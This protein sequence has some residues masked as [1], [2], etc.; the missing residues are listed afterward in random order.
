MQL[1]VLITY[2]NERGLLSECLH[3]LQLQAE[4]PEEI[5]IY[6]DASKYP[7]KDYLINGL[8]VKVIRGETG[9]GPSRGRNRLLGLAQSDYIH[10]H[11]AD[12][13]F[14]PGWAHGIREAIGG[15]PDLILTE[16]DSLR[17]GQAY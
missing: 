16:L 12:D 9:M 10:F 5:W 7:A 2:H 3:S 4:P 1:G 13:F 17:D 8:D 15:N 14:R 11:D 6:D